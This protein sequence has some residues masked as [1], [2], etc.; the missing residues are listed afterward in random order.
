MIIITGRVHI[1]ENCLQDALALCLRHVEHSRAEDGCI[2]HAVTQDVEQPKKLFFFEQ[3]RDN[4]AVQ[5]HFA[6]P[7]SQQ[8][9]K[10]LSPLC[11]SHPELTV[12]QAEKVN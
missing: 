2:S 3:W 12:Y 9:V 8:F 7:T 10:N 1:R 4:D 5:A 6:L 11:E